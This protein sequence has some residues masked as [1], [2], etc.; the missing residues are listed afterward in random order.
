MYLNENQELRVLIA[1][2]EAMVACLTRAELEA[3]GMTVVGTASD[4]RQAVEMVQRLKPD[5]VLM[6]I[7]MPEMDGIDAATAIQQECPTPVVI[8]SAHEDSGLVSMATEAGVGA[9]VVKPSDAEELERA[10]AIAVARHATLMKLRSL[11][12]DLKQTLAEEHTLKGLLPICS[13]CKKIRD[14]EG[15][16]KQ[17]EVYI[18]QRTHTRFSHGYC[19]DCLKQYF[20]E[21]DGSVKPR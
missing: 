18:E 12:R 11:N 7:A 4:G 6:D 17:L 19:P 21:F 10:I 14:D 16:W 3:A 5:V 2:D 1:E 15:Y 9:F 20:P 13:S 8:L